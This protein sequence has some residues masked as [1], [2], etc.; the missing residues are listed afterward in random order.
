MLNPDTTPIQRGGKLID[1]GYPNYLRANY[2]EFCALVAETHERFKHWVNHD[3]PVRGIPVSPVTGV[4]MQLAAIEGAIEGR[5]SMNEQLTEKIA[6]S[7]Q[8]RLKK[9]VVPEAERHPVYPLFMEAYEA[10]R[11]TN[12]VFRSAEQERRFY[13]WYFEIPEDRRLQDSQQDDLGNAV[14]WMSYEIM[15]I[16]KAVIGGV[17]YKTFRCDGLIDMPYRLSSE[18]LLD[19]DSGLNRRLDGIKAYML[20][21]DSRGTPVCLNFEDGN[22]HP[23][24]ADAP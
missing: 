10:A 12:Y 21:A 9:Y 3:N 20:S 4:L 22:P 2:E 5:G 18:G 23:E 6:A 11:A 19:Q 24:N 7:W 8:R 16:I 14:G 13:D 1:N 17:R 15:P